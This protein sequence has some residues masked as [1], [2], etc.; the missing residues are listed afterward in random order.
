[1]GKLLIASQNH[2][3]IAE[4][5]A[6][7]A[8][9]LWELVTPR[10]IGLALTVEESGQSYQQ[11][12]A[13]KSKA[14]TQATGFI[15]LADDSGLE[16]N[17][18]DGQP[19][20]RSA[21]FSPQPGASDGDRRAYL[22]QQLAPHPRPW[23]AQFRCVVAIAS[24]SD[25]FFYTEGFCEGEIIPEERGKGGFGY[26]PIFWLPHLHHTMA[27][28]DMPYKNQISH[29]AHAVRKA[30]PLLSELLNNSKES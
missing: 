18:L 8:G 7:L 26:D 1:M 17:A 25:T 6:L 5:K 27:E 13:L 10:D 16:V 19:G 23:Q 15:S 11:N 4:I 2:G 9:E 22:L 21:R 28:L 20:I 14:Y 24:P 3:K 30:I 29:R 12:A